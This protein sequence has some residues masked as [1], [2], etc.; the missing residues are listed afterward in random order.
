[1]SC[2]NPVSTSH[3]AYRSPGTEPK[4]LDRPER[5]TAIPRPQ[6]DF[7]SLAKSQ[8]TDRTA[9]PQRELLLAL[10]PTCSFCLLA[11]LF[12][13]VSLQTATTLLI[14]ETIAMGL[15]IQRISQH[16]LTAMPA[17][18][19]LHS[20]ILAQNATTKETSTV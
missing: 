13:L 6:V 15:A 12:G 17:S 8:A 19:K 1:M 18:P 7:R 20:T 5:R 2:T 4:R 9:V 11:T 10:L 16:R 14:G 3:T